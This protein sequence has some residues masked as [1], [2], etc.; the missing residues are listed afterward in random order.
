MGERLFSFAIDLGIWYGSNELVTVTIAWSFEQV[1][2]F[3]SPL[4]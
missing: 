3:N 4:V 1:N 2:C